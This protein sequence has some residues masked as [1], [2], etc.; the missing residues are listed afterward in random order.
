[1]E[2]VFSHG[3]LQPDAFMQSDVASGLCSCCWS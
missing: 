2:Y 3:S 1:M